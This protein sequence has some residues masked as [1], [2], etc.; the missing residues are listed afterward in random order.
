MISVSAD[1]ADTADYPAMWKKGIVRIPTAGKT[2]TFPST[3]NLP[4]N[5][6]VRTV[7]FNS[8]RIREIY[9]DLQ[10]WTSQSSCP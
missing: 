10:K 7:R 2:E 9:L 1:T 3:Y 6:T 5:W 8:M 4:K